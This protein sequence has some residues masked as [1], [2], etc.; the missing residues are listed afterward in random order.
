MDHTAFK[1]V[2]DDIY[3]EFEDGSVN[4]RYIFVLAS[5]LVLEYVVHVFSAE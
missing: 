3:I 5:G 4:V 1:K 2:S